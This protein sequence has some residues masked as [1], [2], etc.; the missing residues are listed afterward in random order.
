MKRDMRSKANEVLN[1]KKEEDIM[2]KQEEKPKH[3][4]NTLWVED[5]KIEE[6]IKSFIGITITNQWPDVLQEKIT[7]SGLQGILIRGITFKRFII[8]FPSKDDMVNTDK[9]LLKEW[10]TEVRKWNHNDL[11]QPRLAW[12]QCEGLPI[13]VRIEGNLNMMLGEW[14]NWFYRPTLL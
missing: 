8:S 6:A 11:I 5:K 4:H 2:K 7:L 10:F 1:N 14:G 3:R 13:S 12:I 9:N